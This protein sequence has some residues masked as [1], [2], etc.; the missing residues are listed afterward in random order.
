[1]LTGLCCGFLDARSIVLRPDDYQVH[2]VTSVLKRF[3]RS[4]DDPLLTE[5]LRNRWIQS[6]RK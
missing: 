4:I 5:Q 2:E 1:M 6:S 3:I